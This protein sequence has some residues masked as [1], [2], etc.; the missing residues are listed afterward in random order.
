MTSSGPILLAW[1]FT[2][3]GDGQSSAA[4]T[5]GAALTS[6]RDLA[7]SVVTSPGG[8][9]GLPPGTL[10]ISVAG[11][12]LCPPSGDN[13]NQYPSPQGKGKPKNY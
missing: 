1:Q 8:S 12:C 2:V 9:D 13:K 7:A 4:P 3:T 10:N 6:S 5:G 11:A